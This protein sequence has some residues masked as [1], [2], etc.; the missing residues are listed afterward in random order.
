[1]LLCLDKT[2]VLLPLYTCSVV[3]GSYVH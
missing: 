3:K 2:E 1:M